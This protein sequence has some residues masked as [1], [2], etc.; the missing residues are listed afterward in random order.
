MTMHS[1]IAASIENP[2]ELE[3]LYRDDPE[4]FKKVYREV[5]EDQPDAIL[6][7]AW[8]ARLEY[9]KIAVRKLSSLDFAI[10]VILCLAAGSLLKIPDWTTVQ[11]NAFYPRF[12]VLIPLSAMFLFKMHMCGWPGRLTAAGCTVI[13]CFTAGLLA[14]P[15]SWDDV[16]TLAGIN[17]PFLLW[18][19]YGASCLGPD[20]RSPGKRIEYI[21][22]TGEFIIHAGLLIIGGGILLFLTDGLLDLLDIRSGWIIE[23]MAVYGSASI[24]LIAAW[25]TDSYSA[26]RRLVPL[27][28]RIFSPLLLLLILVYMGA[29]AW[30]INDLFTDRSTLLI[31]NILLLSVLS[32]ALFTLTGRGEQAENR[33]ESIVI[34]LMIGATLVLDT[35]AICAIGWRIQEYGLTVNRLAVLGSNLAVFGNLAFMGTGYIRYWRGLGSLED[36]ESTIAAYLPV[37]T[38]WTFFSVF[39]QPWLFQY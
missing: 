36:I 27:L 13:G 31:Y 35:L 34:S 11:D 20:W 6:L 17:L 2:D 26:A 25:A 30:N 23:T 24:P 14:I 33:I 19:L 29:M 16:Y 28:A 39:I 38:I 5:L 15:G 12:S 1:K 8:R 10:M 18:T 4:T 22:F 3:Q 7:R 32:T 37:Y 9:T 21:R